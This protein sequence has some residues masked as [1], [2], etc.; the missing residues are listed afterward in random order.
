MYTLP[1]LELLQDS[2][3]PPLTRERLTRIELLLDVRFPAEY[4]EFLLQFNGGQFKKP[5]M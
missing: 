1:I 5:V 3:D 2:E 4:A